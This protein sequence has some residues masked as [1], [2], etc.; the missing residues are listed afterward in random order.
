M[1]AENIGDV[2]SK[3]EKTTKVKVVTDG[4]DPGC[5]SIMLFCLLSVLLIYLFWALIFGVTIHGQHYRVSCTI[6]HGVTFQ[7]F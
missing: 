6:D 4:G 5:L 1:D 3:E 2:K 7:G